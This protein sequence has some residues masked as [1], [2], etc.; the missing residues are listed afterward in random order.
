MRQRMRRVER[1][2]F[3]KFLAFVVAGVVL[4]VVIALGVLAVG[5][6]LVTPPPSAHPRLVPS[7]TPSTPIA[8]IPTAT[9]ARPAS[10]PLI[11]VNVSVYT[12]EGTMADGKPTHVGACAVSVA[13]FPLGTILNLY[14]TDGS[15]NRQCLAEDTGDSI[16]YGQID[17]AMPGDSIGATQWGRRHLWV[18][19][20]RW[21]WSEKGTPPA[22]S[23][24]EPREKGETFHALYACPTMGLPLN[25]KRQ[26]SN[27]TSL[28]VQNGA[29][30]ANY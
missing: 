10:T 30:V 13:Q 6:V 9:H 25:E 16:G 24:Y 7:A 14:N 11:P 2:R 19:V 22:S 15:F 28:T 26:R 20:M 29:T 23:M 3:E 21:G 18:R 5:N 8:I 27:D 1:A 4:A 17:L 12:I